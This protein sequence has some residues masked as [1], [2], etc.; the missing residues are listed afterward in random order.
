M[1]ILSDLSKLVG[2]EDEANRKLWEARNK[3]RDLVNDNLTKLADMGVIKI[4]VNR[5][6]LGRILSVPRTKA[7]TIFR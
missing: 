6:V 1:D 5:Q 3:T 4:S 2:E 7:E